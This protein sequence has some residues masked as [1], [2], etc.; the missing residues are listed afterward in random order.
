MNLSRTPWTVEDPFKYLNRIEAIK[1]VATVF[2]DIQ[3]DGV[4]Y[5]EPT[6]LWQ[7]NPKEAIIAI[8][9]MG[10][11]LA[12]TALLAIVSSGTME[13]LV[14]VF[15]KEQIEMIDGRVNLRGRDIKFQVFDDIEPDDIEPDNNVLVLKDIKFP[16]PSNICL[17]DKGCKSDF[18]VKGNKP[19]WLKR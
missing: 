1:P 7:Y 6:M 14:K 5:S 19:K 4:A 8:S 9:S 13:T 15:E 10:E 3:T 2:A 17:L 16:E 12:K 18:N 11:A